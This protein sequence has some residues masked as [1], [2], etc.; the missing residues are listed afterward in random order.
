VDILL[1]RHRDQVAINVLRADGP[2][3]VR[4]VK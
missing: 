4:V 3:E 2:V 1:H